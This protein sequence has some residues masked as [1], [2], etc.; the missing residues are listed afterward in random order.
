MSQRWVC[1][2]P[3]INHVYHFAIFPWQELIWSL[4]L[5]LF[6]FPISTLSLL[7]M[8]KNDPHNE[9]SVSASSCYHQS[10]QWTI[11]SEE[12]RE[13]LQMCIT[14]WCLCLIYSLG[15]SAPFPPSPEHS[16]LI[17][18]HTHTYTSCRCTSWSYLHSVRSHLA[19]EICWVTV[20]LIRTSK[21]SG[22]KWAEPTLKYF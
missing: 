4:L 19:S 15:K 10:I 21:I 2:T 9:M 22:V 5:L 20:Y 3:T 13:C 7:E 8:K 11:S 14:S 18:T 17:S 6:S 16:P 1:F 12:W